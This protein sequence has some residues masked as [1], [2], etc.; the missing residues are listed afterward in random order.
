MIGYIQA[1]CNLISA[2]VHKIWTYFTLF[3]SYFAKNKHRFFF[4]WQNCWY[5]NWCK[6][7]QSKMPFNCLFTSRTIWSLDNINSE[8]GK[9]CVFFL[10][11]NCCILWELWF[12]MSLSI[13][14]RWTGQQA[15]SMA[16]SRR[17]PSVAPSVEWYVCS[18]TLIAHFTV[19]FGR[20]SYKCMVSHLL[21]SQEVCVVI[22]RVKLMTPSWGLQRTTALWQSKLLSVDD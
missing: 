4:H 19:K 14:Y 5:W 15:G 17:M 2:S 11:Q 1:K 20:C 7:V 8:N 9:R 22:Y 12:L 6:C 18:I 10:E 13:C 21:W 3:T 16:S